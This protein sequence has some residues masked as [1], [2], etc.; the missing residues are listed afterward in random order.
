[1]RPFC[2]RQTMFRLA[3]FGTLI[4]ADGSVAG[5]AAP[6]GLYGTWDLFEIQGSGMTARVRLTVEEGRVISAT[7]CSYADKK[8]HVQ[9]NSYAKI[10]ADEISIMEDNVAQREYR[11]GFLNCKVS[12]DRGTIQ[13]RLVDDHLVLR[14]AGQDDA[15][16]LSRSGASFVQARRLDG[17]SI[18]LR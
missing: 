14:M 6:P 8:V 3:I 11:P 16:A 4:F 12:L 5:S 1:M 15:I 9:A 7:S 10:T 17:S 18:R 2:L 13:Y